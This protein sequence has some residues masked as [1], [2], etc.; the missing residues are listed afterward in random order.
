MRRILVLAVVTCALTLSIVPAQ[1]RYGYTRADTWARYRH[2]IAGREG[3]RGTLRVWTPVNGSTRRVIWSVRNSGT[4]IPKIQKVTFNG[5]DDG[6]GFRFRY[7]TPDGKDVTWRVTH[8][9]YVAAA[10]PFH[11]AWLNVRIRSTVSGRSY[12][13]VLSGLGNGPAT[14]ATDVKVRAHS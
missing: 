9:G 10:G 6:D 7:I 13:C 2:R 11:R 14:S 1:A 8:D 3:E 4:A 5:C 12:T